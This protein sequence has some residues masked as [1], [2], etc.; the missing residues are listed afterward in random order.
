MAPV[1]RIRQTEHGG[2]EV[3][4]VEEVPDLDPGPGQVRVD[5]A[6]AG[7]HLVDTT[8]RSGAGG[9]P[10][11]PEPPTTPGREVAGVVDRVG[12]DVDPAW[13]GRRVVAH[14]GPVG[15][16]YAEQAVTDVDRLHVVPDALALDVAVAAIGTGRTATGVL[17]LVPLAATDRVVVTAASGGLGSVL[18]RAGVSAG[19]RT[20]GLARGQVKTR[21][22]ERAAGV[23]VVDHTLDGWTDRFLQALG[24]P[25]TVVLDGVGGDQARTLR[26]LLT[27]DGVLATYTGE[28][29]SAFGDGPEVRPLLGPALLSRPGGLRSLEEEALARAADGSR[30][31][32][33]GSRF[34]LADAVAAHR[35][36]EAR[37][38]VGKVV[39]TTG[40]GADRA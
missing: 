19:A 16:G 11:S 27:D 6:V 14:L 32:V 1:K 9:P 35:A 33:V 40:D 12:P 34:A 5:V 31:P 29:A 39:L 23:A 3:L 28:D 10:G 20:V 22:V 7:V 24:G 38:T 15:G 4:V 13:V 8:I 17:D 18:V 25:P 2:P 37:A 30:T 26:A 36:L 21:F